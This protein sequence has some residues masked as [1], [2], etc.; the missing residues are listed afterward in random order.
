MI[1]KGGMS[2]L[3]VIGRLRWLLQEDSPY[4]KRRADADGLHLSTIYNQDSPS[5]DSDSEANL[6]PA[7]PIT[8]QA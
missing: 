5:F 4:R 2:R 3:W 1:R 8:H 6:L 7:P